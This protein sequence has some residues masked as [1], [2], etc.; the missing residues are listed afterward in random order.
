MSKRG[1][2]K[3]AKVTI[4][5][6]FMNDGPK[7]L[8][9]LLFLL[10]MLVQ[11]A[12]QTGDEANRESEEPPGPV[13]VLP[14]REP[15]MPPLTYVVRR[16]VKE[17]MANN[18]EVL[19]LDMSTDGGRVDVTDE[20][21]DII[22]KF[23]GETVTYVNQKAYS[24]GAFIAVATKKIYMAPESVIG[25][26]A[27]IMLVPGGGVSEMPDTL[28]VKM[29]SAIRAKIRAQAQKNGHS[30]EVV[31]AMI[32][33]SKEL[34]IDGKE[35]SGDGDI[36]TLT[37]TEAEESYG[38]PAKPLLSL[39]TVEDLDAL[40]KTLGLETK[41][42]VEIEP[43]GAERVGTWINGVSSLLLIGGLVGLYLE[44]KTPGFGLP[45]LAGI[46]LLATYF[47]GGYI[48]GLSGMEWLAFF[49]I[50][51]FLILIE[52]F[53]IP[54]TF[55]AGLVGV[56]LVFASLL[57]AMVDVYPGGPLMPT[58]PQL[59]NPLENLV[60]AFLVSLV[61][62]VLLAK[63]LPKT[64]LYSSMASPTAVGMESVQEMEKRQS[65]LLGKRGVAVGPLRPGGK[66]RFGG[67]T[68][69][70]IAESGYADRG[71]SLEV[72]R[73]NGNHA[74]VRV[75]GERAVDTGAQADAV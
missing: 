40:M 10:M 58:R 45:G 6:T 16:G 52:V 26:A 46:T 4:R 38:E 23:E 63:W 2:L 49:G 35:L 59:S 44:F 53:V 51:L 47:F 66:G 37:N 11:G 64:K 61:I 21:I 73:F 25:A 74:V 75:L 5:L 50:G 57:M 20:I 19:I 39:G 17:A 70:V 60:V 14:I 34:V 32:D 71:A 30:I 28:E 69:D 68:L 36:L 22:N 72:S 24:A 55:L 18:A 15:I 41:E 29:N 67:V 62:M 27:P 42:R 43:T 56:G 12:G 31:E 48:A 33:K 9:S 13:Y 7:R 1:G 65:S 54:G 8:L 3:S